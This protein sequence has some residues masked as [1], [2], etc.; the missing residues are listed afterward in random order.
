MAADRRHR[1]R[2]SFLTNDAPAPIASAADLL[3]DVRF[4]PA[5]D[6]ALIEADGAQFPR[7]TVD[8]HGKAGSVLTRAADDDRATMR[9]E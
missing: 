9:I 6:G 4:R 8:W 5:W 1:F 2:V 3:A 7:V